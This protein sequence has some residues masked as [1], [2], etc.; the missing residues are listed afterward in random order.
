[1][2]RAIV[3]VYI[4]LLGEVK[5]IVRKKNLEF[6]VSDLDRYIKTLGGEV[7]DGLGT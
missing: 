2:S 4:I 5:G 3:I 1:V 7:A 6:L